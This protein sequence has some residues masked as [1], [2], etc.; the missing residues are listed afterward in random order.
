MH[1]HAEHDGRDDHRN[2]LQKRIA[3]DLQADRK[4]GHGHAE[5]DS[6]QQCGEDLDE[7]QTIERLSRN[8][9]SSGGYGRHRTLPSVQDMS[10][11]KLATSVPAIAPRLAKADAKHH[12]RRQRKC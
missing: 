6:E 7:Q 9:R 4:F 2:Q 11:T 12:D 8:R 10:A 1:H 5:H 3:E